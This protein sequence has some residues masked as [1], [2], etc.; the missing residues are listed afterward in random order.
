LPSSPLVFHLCL[1]LL[2]PS[3]SS[4]QLF[5]ALARTSLR[6]PELLSI[7]QWFVAVLVQASKVL[8]MAA[9]GRCCRSA[10]HERLC[11]SRGALSHTLEK[12]LLLGVKASEKRVDE[13]DAV[14]RYKCW[15]S[16]M[17]SYRGDKQLYTYVPTTHEAARLIYRSIAP[18]LRNQLLLS[19]S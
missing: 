2:L 14:C 1:P 5:S 13:V 11:L 3:Q 9:V 19:L 15:R 18:S 4:S 6:S 16:D 10:A 12:P 8:R 17:P 7:R